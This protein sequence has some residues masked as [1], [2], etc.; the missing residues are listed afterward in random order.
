VDEVGSGWEDIA[1]NFRFHGRE[2]NLAV[3][4]ARASRR[5]WTVGWR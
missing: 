2:K 4:G 1:P 3:D 5:I